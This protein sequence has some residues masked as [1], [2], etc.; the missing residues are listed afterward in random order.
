MDVNGEKRVERGNNSLITVVAVEMVIPSH[1]HGLFQYV[2]PKSML[3][4]SSSV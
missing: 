2:L 1:F 4:E 3:F